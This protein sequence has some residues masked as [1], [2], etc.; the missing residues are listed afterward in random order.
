[1]KTKIHTKS[2]DFTNFNHP[3]GNKALELVENKVVV[4]EEEDVMRVDIQPLH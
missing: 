4:V 2:Y 3:G 1:M